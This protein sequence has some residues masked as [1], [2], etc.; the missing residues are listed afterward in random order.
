MTR[1]GLLMCGHVD[2]RAEA[3]AGDYPEL[4]GALLAGEHLELVRYDL[5]AGR[6]PDSERECDG[7][8]C[9]PAR[10]SAFDPHRWIR[11]AEELHRRIL[12]AEVPYVGICFGH[13]LLAQALG[14]R[15]E[16]A[17]AGWNVG[18]HEYRIDRALP[19][20]DGSATAIRL[21]AS[22]QDQVVSVPPDATVFAHAP[23]GSCPVGGMVVGERAW[24]LQLHPEFTPAL[25]A[26]LLDLRVDLIGAAKVDT[27]RA[28]LGAPLSRAQVAGWIGRFFRGA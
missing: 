1:I 3:V 11:D 26:C 21:I 8:L 13:Q 6:F 9:S 17:A 5:D 28:S 27:A 15:V 23:D 12:A 18:A 19:F 2:A 16:R 22:H 4:F 10:D 24:T 25:A 7:W 14:G 20:M